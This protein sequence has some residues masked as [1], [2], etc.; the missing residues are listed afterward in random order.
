MHVATVPTIA[1]VILAACSAPGWLWATEFGG[2]DV[3]SYH[4]Q[5]PRE[6]YD[7]GRIVPLD[8]SRDGSGS[9]RG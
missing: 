5:L 9:R 8:H 3:L 2:Y 1:I 6:W 7:A 4:L